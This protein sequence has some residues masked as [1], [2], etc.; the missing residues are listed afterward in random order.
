LTPAKKGRIFEIDDPFDCAQDR[1]SIYDLLL[2]G[3]GVL[4]RPGSGRRLWPEEF[5]LIC[6]Y[7]RLSAVICGLGKR[8]LMID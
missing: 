1:F 8:L 2:G 5:T 7:L 6:V 3:L 4:L